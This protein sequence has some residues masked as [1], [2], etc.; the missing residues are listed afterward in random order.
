MASFGVDI[1]NSRNVCS[2]STDE[3]S[4]DQWVKG[5]GDGIVYARVRNVYE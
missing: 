3:K 5:G 4:G 2:H 1:W